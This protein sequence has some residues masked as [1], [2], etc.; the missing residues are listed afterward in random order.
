LVLEIQSAFDIK[1][2]M[3]TDFE[4][5]FIDRSII[6][7]IGNIFC[8]LYGSLTFY[9]SPDTLVEIIDIG[10]TTDMG[11]SPVKIAVTSKRLKRM[12]TIESMSNE[13]EGIQLDKKEIIPKIVDEVNNKSASKPVKPVRLS[14]PLSNVK[15]DV[16]TPKGRNPGM[17]L[18]MAM[19]GGKIVDSQNK[20][21]ATRDLKSN[22]KYSKNRSR[23]KR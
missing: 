4:N 1:I 5:R 8:S 7:T 16:I 6:T 14:V 9:T 2:K 17:N 23:K 21:K 18:G 19:A 20:N 12:N 13:D 3:Q 15:F 10:V 22:D 11:I